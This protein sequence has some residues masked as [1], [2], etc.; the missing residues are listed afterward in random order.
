VDVPALEK[1]LQEAVGF[2][3]HIERVDQP[4]DAA[5]TV[6]CEGKNSVTRQELG[7]DF[8]ALP[9]AQH[10]IATR[11]RCEQPHQQ[12]AFQWFSQSSH[13]LS[14]L[15]LLPL[16][17]PQG[18]EVAVVWSLP[19]EQ[20]HRLYDIS[21]EA[22]ANEL[23]QA[24][25]HQL[26]SL[27]LCAPK[28]K[29]PLQTAQ[30]KQWSGR[31]A[32]GHSW[33]LAGD[34]AHTVHPLAGMGLNL[35]LADAQALASTLAQR[36]GKD[37]WR[38]VG[39][40]SLLRQYERARKAGLWPTWIACDGLQAA[41]LPFTT[42]GAIFSKLGHEQFQPINISQTMDCSSSH[43]PFFLT[44]AHMRHLFKFITLLLTCL[45][46]PMAWGQGE[47]ASIRKILKD[48]MPHIHPIDEIKR[49]PMPGLFE[50]QGR[51]I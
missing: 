31:F 25:Q 36:E 16:G 18:D 32:N 50:L 12:Q 44:K 23:S 51:W 3:Q 40:P 22:F 13:A 4:V 11:V 46:I 37:Y 45:V 43:E 9:Y 8:D 17:G 29:W 41:V 1:L 34:A 42:T 19:N 39:D 21:D 20:A 38:S 14:I 33:V 27:Q 47:E 49:T 30:A 35:G 26:G 2:Q 15:A 6:I 48:R 28:S 24:C 10:A 7:I 5:L